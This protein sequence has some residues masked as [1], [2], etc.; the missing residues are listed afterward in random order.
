MNKQSVKLFRH[1]QINFLETSFIKQQN[2]TGVRREWSKEEA[3]I[4]CCHFC[5]L[6][7]GQRKQKMTHSCSTGSISNPST[8]RCKA[9]NGFTISELKTIARRLG[10]S[11]SGASKSTLC[12]AIMR[13]AG[14]KSKS[15]S[16]SK[17]R[18][19]R[20]SASK[21]SKSRRPRHSASKKRRSA[22]KSTSKKGK[23]TKS[24]LATRRR[25]IARTKFRRAVATHRSRSSGRYVPSRGSGSFQKRHFSSKRRAPSLPAQSYCGS[26]RRGNDGELWQS[27]ADKNGVCHWYKY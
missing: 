16:V 14:S 19:S 9:C 15:R 18:R 20:Q 12:R 21:K 27:R 25:S 6:V 2:P 10:A 3:K 13:R 4:K 22:S 17:N 11:S 26:V 23:L 5:S 7:F 24:Q 1:F 8:G